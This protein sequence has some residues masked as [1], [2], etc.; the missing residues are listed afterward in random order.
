[1]KTPDGSGETTTRLRRIRGVSWEW[2]EGAPVESHGREAGVIAQEVQVVFPELVKRAPT[3]YLRVNYRG[4]AAKIGEAMIEL[5]D[6]IARI[7]ASDVDPVEDA[8]ARLDAGEGLERADYTALVGALVE[9]AKDLD[10]RLLAL[11]RG[12][13]DQA[14]D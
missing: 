12:R 2:R 10:A 13:T 11:E 6:R 4:L 14:H 9:A 7:E 5:R 1:M 3:G 8:L